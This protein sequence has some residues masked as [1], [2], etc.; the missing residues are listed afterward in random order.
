MGSSDTL[1]QL[2]NVFWLRPETA[3][4][5]EIDIKTMNAFEMHSPSLDLGCGDGTFSFIRAGGEFDR[6]YD[7]FRSVAQLDRFFQNVDVFDAY[8]ESLS[9]VVTKSPSYQIDV[10][11]DHKKNLLKKAG[12][13]GLYG[14]FKQG[15][16]NQS[17]PFPDASFKSVFS[18]IVYW[19]DSPQDVISEISRILKPGGRACLMLPNITF[20]QFG[21]YNQ[22]Y[23]KGGD[24]RW[25]FLEMLDRGRFSDNIRQAKSLGEWQAMFEQAGLAIERHHSH[26][27]KLTIQ[28]WDI[29]LRPLFPVLLEMANELSPEKLR[30]IKVKWIQ[31]MMAFIEPLIEIDREIP[32]DEE[33][34]FHCFEL[35][36]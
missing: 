30:S 19:L 18:N 6:S 35:R 7:T 14:S 17:L 22:L 16:A 24:A 3:L 23:V 11:F 20:P 25:K 9:T 32:G 26:L 15:D 21:F 36:K 4:W 33:P 2:L 13:L 28:I 8:D 31:T 12:Q 27:S 34:A 29:G 1:T 10:G 5:R